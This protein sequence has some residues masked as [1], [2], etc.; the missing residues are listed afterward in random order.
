MTKWSWRVPPSLALLAAIGVAAGCGTKD[1]PGNP[2]PGGPKDGGGGSPDI[3]RIM[4]RLG[5]GPQALTAAIGEELKSDEPPWDDLQGQ[6][7]E[8]ARLTAELGRYD[9]PRGDKESWQQRTGDY[10]EAAA[11]LDRAA[12]ARD[13]DA[14][15]EAHGRLNRSCAACHREHRQMGPPGKGG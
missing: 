7:K 6:A 5:K 8:Y 3:R 4:D 9:P 12:Q 2:P 11:A 13:R 14:A 15:K 1:Q 10:A